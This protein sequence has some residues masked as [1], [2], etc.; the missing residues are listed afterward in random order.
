MFLKRDY[1]HILLEYFS[2]MRVC[3]VTSVMSDSLQ[4]H[5]LQSTR[6]LCPWDSPGKNTGVGHHVFL[7]GIF[8]TQGLNPRLF[9]LLHWQAGSLPLV[10]WEALSNK[11]RPYIHLFNYLCTLVSQI[12]IYFISWVIIQHDA[13][14][15]VA[16]ITS[17]LDMEKSFWLTSASP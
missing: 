14:Y 8:L 12:H 3:S 17:V 5:G 10:L 15:F 4:P 11:K 9:C 1:V 13:I 6:L 7:Q 16:G 2:N